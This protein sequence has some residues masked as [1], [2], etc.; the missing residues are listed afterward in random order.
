MGHVLF[1]RKGSVH[2]KPLLPSGYTELAY[3]Q[4]SGTQYIDSGLKPNQNM[5][6]V[7]KLSTS[8]TGSHTVFGADLSW[9]DDGFA[10]GVGFT[11]Y[12]KETGTISGLNNGSPHEVDF[13]KNI[14]SMDGSTVLTMGASTFSIP[15]NLVL[16]A[17]N[18]AGGIGEKTTMA[19]YYC[20][21]FDGD[22]L[23]R[24]YIPCINAS[25]AVGLYDLVGRQFYGNAGTGMFSAGPR[26]ELTLPDGYTELE[27]IQSSG[28]QYVNTGVKPGNTTR[29]VMDFEPAKLGS[30]HLM[31]A[32]VRDTSKGGNQFVVG[33][34]GHKS[35]AV[36]RSDYGASQVNFT[37][38]IT[39]VTRHQLV[40]D[41]AS[42][43][44][45]S[46]SV[47]NTATTF[48]STYPLFLFAGNQGGSVVSQIS[49][50]LY[51]C[52]IYDNGTLIRDYWPCRNAS[53]VAGLYDFVGQQFYANA[54]TGTFLDNLIET[55]AITASNIGT[56]FTVTNGTYKFN[57]SG[58][59]FTSNNNGANSSTASTVLTAKQNIIALTFDYSYSSEA[60]Y[61]KFTLKVGG[62]T[63]ADGVSG[64]TT[65]KSY[66][67][68]LS[69]GQKIEFTYAKDSSQ[70]KNDDQCTF[71]NMSITIAKGA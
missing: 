66:S 50:K 44:I 43:T 60:N 48:S 63:I 37:T 3:I 52:Q 41:G 15:Y 70:H 21:I 62:T 46:E 64:A 58:S 28:T 45:D 34:T 57:G 25:G 23:L 65:N 4:S 18:R 11:H 61:D 38:A 13:N 14:I 17:D 67:G 51:S 27:Y 42:C 71:S 8:E 36:W 53:G 69:S 40:K 22:T 1:L 55:V 10:L 24:D 39:G 31:A 32:G 54:G 59:V 35:P 26:D 5:R 56:Y 49:M 33:W 7:V 47:S 19:L 20:R 29:L 6:V 2:K 9:T 16:F 68:S 12:G 30:T